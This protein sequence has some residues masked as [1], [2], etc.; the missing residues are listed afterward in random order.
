M[1]FMSM[2]MLPYTA[3]GILQKWQ[4]LFWDGKKILK[5]ETESRDVRVGDMMKANNQN[6]AAW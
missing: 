1:I 5:N 2:S 3:N 6:D 4:G